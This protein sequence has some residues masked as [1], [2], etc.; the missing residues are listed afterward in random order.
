MSRP[1]KRMR[2]DGGV[3]FDV[4]AMVRAGLRNGTC[5]LVFTNGEAWVGDL[6][7][8]DQ[9]QKGWLHL[10]LPYGEQTI[11]VTAVARPFGGYQWYWRCPMTGSRCAVLWKPHGRDLFASQR[12]WRGRRMAYGSQ[13][14]GPAQASGDQASAA[15]TPSSAAARTTRTPCG[16]PS[17]SAGEPSIAT[18]LGSTST[19][20]SSRPVSRSLMS[21]WSGH[22]TGYKGG[23]SQQISIFLG[24][25]ARAAAIACTATFSVSPVRQ[26]T[27]AT[28]PRHRDAKF[29]NRWN[30]QQ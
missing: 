26:R 28:S 7:M 6:R 13:F 14:L 10:H 11:E 3:R 4:N 27:N 15:S 9:H 17:G 20:R 30:M 5:K 16:S 22:S 24:Q 19:M 12:Y 29:L 2:L 25:A 23:D 1:R 18:V 8:D 21:A